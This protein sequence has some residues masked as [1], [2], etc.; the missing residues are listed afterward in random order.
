MS[1]FEHADSAFA[2]DAP[3]LA[4]SKPTL[5]FMRATG[6]C[7]AAGLRQHHPSDAAGVR[8]GLVRSRRK[9]AIT[10]REIW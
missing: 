6:R 10:R 3:P 8:G 4:T 7:F 9:A 5:P 1:T 2:S